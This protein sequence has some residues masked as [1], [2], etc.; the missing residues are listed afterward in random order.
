MTR[1]RRWPFRARALS[2]FAIPRHVS[3]N[4]TYPCSRMDQERRLPWNR[5][6][7]LLYAVIRIKQW[8]D[9]ETGAFS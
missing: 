6:S 2:G 7:L 5:R 3:N 1:V 9:S 8:S 4:D